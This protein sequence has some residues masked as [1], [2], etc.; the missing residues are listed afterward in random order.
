[1][2]LLVI[3]DSWASAN[4]ADTDNQY[5]G[6]PL[7]LGVDPYRRQAVAGSTAAQ[8]AADFDGR[9]VRAMATECDA[10]F[11]SVGGNDVGELRGFADASRAIF[12][13][14][15]VVGSF[16]ERLVVVMLYAN[17]FPGN[18]DAEIAVGMLNDAIHYA[19]R[20]MKV[21]FFHSN[22]LLRPEHFLQ[23]HQRDIHP[24]RAG[25]ALVAEAIGKMLKQKG[26]EP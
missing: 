3:G 6:W 13:Y 25:W 9:L 7:I 12:I 15:K 14:T 10:V 2:S 18:P 19:C 21:L 16:A 26:V 5:A 23:R 24:T 20:G 17:P 4:E 8:W 11:I 1:V 22:K